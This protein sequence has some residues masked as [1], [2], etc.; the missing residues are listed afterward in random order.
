[1]SDALHFMTIAEAGAR[2]AKKELS[3]VELIDAYISRIEALN[4]QLDAFVTPTLEL[5]RDQAKAT[6]AEIAGGTH[7]G[8]L[9]G[10]PFGLKDIYETKGILTSGHSKVMQDHI[11]EQGCDDD[12]KTFRCRN[13]PDRKTINARIRSRRP[14]I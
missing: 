8:P 12:G 11:P 2:I 10:L 14:I 5:A 4:A 7:K 9:H 13:G 3:P 1:M 6:E